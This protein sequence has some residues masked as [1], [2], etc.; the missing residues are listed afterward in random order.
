MKAVVMTAPGGPEVMELVERPEP[1]PGPGEALVAIAAS[2]VKRLSLML[3]LLCTRTRMSSKRSMNSR[4]RE[5]S[6]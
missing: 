2:G 4:S 3:T 5:P 6:A 1:I